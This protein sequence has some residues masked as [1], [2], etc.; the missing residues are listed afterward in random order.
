L[1]SIGRV[2]VAADSRNYGY[3]HALVQFSKKSIESEYH[4]FDIHISAQLYLKKFYESLGFVA[5]G[6]EYLE[7]E[8]PHI[9]MELIKK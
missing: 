6:E 3:G 8:L 9:A 4:E 5:L 7:D 2:V 1:A